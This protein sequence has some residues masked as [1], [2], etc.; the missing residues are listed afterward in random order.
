MCAQDSS[1]RSDPFIPIPNS[2]FEVFTYTLLM[3]LCSLRL[4]VSEFCSF[5]PSEVTNVTQSA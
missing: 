4:V 1:S 3:V 5:S 2:G